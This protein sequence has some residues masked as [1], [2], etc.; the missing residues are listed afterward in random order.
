MDD[1]SLQTD[2]PSGPKP[3]YKIDKIDTEHVTKGFAMIPTDFEKLRKIAMSDYEPLRCRKE[4]HDSPLEPYVPLK[5]IMT[6]FLTKEVNGHLQV[7]YKRSSKDFVSQKH[8]D[9]RDRAYAMQGISA[10]SMKREVRAAM[11]HGTLTDFDQCSSHQS[12]ILSAM[13]ADRTKPSVQWIS[14]YVHNKKEVREKIANTYFQGDMAKSKQLFQR[15]MFGGHTTIDHPIVQGMI[16]EF[17][18]FTSKVI[19]HNQSIV[20]IVQRRINIKNAAEITKAVELY[21]LSIEQ[22]RARYGKK[23]WRA[24]LMSMWC[25]NKESL[26]IEAVLGWAIEHNLVQH[27]R[28]DN[29]FD[30]LMI[31][32]EDV[33]EF[34][35]S[36]PVIFS[37]EHLLK[38]FNKVGLKRTG[39]DIK[40]EVKDMQPEHDTFWSEH[41]KFE[42]NAKINAPDHFDRDV[43]MQ[44]SSVQ[45]RIEYF[46]EHF[47]YIEDQHKVLHFQ[48]L[49]FTRPD[50]S[51]LHERNL[52]WANF[53]EFMCT[54]GNI[55]S[56]MQN[57]KGHDIPLAKLWLESPDRSQYCKVDAFPYAAVYNKELASK[58]S[59]NIYNTFAGYPKDVWENASDTEFT[60][61]E[62]MKLLGPFMQLVSHL[63]G[64]KCHDSTG[65][66]PV[67]LD[68]YPPSDR[69]QVELFLHFMGHRITKPAD[70]RLPY[71]V[72]FQSECG[73]GKNSLMDPFARLVGSMHYKCSSDMDAFCGT[74][75]EG[76]I[77][78]IIAVL[79]E[80]DIS[81]TAK[82]TSRFKEFVTE[83]HQTSN[84]KFMR[85]FEYAVWAAIIV[86]TNSKIP[87][88]IEP[89][90][91]E[92]RIILFESNSWTACYWKHDMWSYIRESLADIK[93]LR[94]LR[95][96]L[97]T[98][99]YKGFDFRKARAENLKRPAYTQLALHFTPVEIMFV[100]NYI[101]TGY[102]S[103]FRPT[104]ANP[105]FWELD[106]WDS[107]TTVTGRDFYDMS[108]TFY[109][110]MNLTSSACDKSLHAFNQRIEGIYGIEK[111]VSTNRCVKFEFTPRVVYADFLAKCMVDIDT[112]EPELV[113]TLTLEEA[114]ANNDPSV[115][116]EQSS[117]AMKS[118]FSM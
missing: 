91:R 114:D 26:V 77:S 33:D 117:D 36:S 102:F 64:A 79:N 1:T 55:P 19:E 58:T 90:N 10:G 4:S 38:K 25:R 41:A 31:P 52:I 48:T 28:F 95:Q 7:S 24:S 82:V 110:E 22:A 20:P 27:R 5:K 39:Y 74:H 93:F 81:S 61:E 104:E 106:G 76:L 83:K 12:L 111:K 87:M 103:A 67:S 116:T 6:K 89:M 9:K 73:T 51:V 62:M 54:F 85:P 78:K 14:H 15:I 92:R 59:S 100:R 69:T 23:D 16:N 11:Y 17:Q 57:D 34:L 94:A 49:N 43:L 68:D 97:T 3:S 70:P 113:S 18:M 30:G 21:G 35:R 46:N 115:F 75:S 105:R 84:V 47:H 60:R 53:R 71:Y 50:G 66:F 107:P 32:E 37:I 88:R 42:S 96:Y 8:S 98:L 80:A 108:K 63:V 56:N 112:V 40:W 99:D 45:Q 72:C 109:S 29:S 2:P 44:M 118:L 13:L 101:E 65:M 86:L